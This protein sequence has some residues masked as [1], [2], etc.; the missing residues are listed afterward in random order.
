MHR[1]SI[2]MLLGAVGYCSSVGAATIN[3]GPVT[4]ITGASDVS[5][6][7][8]THA[9]I[10]FGDTGA[11]AVTVNGITFQPLTVAG[12]NTSSITNG[13]VTLTETQTVLHGNNGPGGSNTGAFAAM[14]DADYKTLLSSEINSVAIFDLQL[15]T[16]GL[17]LG[18]TYQVQLWCNYSSTNNTNKVAITGGPI[19]DDNTTDAFGGLGQYVIGSFIADGSSQMIEMKGVPGTDLIQNPDFSPVS[20]PLIN[21]F[22]IALVPEPA[23]LTLFGLAAVALSRRQKANRV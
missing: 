8:T 20:L 7:G 9:A 14:A 19:L 21:A 17:S 12:F 22:R 11:P 4:T 23:T 2:F 13:T 16:S 1:K 10:N 15:T 3:W 5:T 6:A 18:Q